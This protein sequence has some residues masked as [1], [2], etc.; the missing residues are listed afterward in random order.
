MHLKVLH[1]QAKKCTYAGISLLRLIE[2]DRE[3][4]AGERTVVC[5]RETR[6]F[7]PWSGVSQS[8]TSSRSCV[9][10]LL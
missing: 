6:T 4:R 1:K 5:V 7:E 9:P 3:K 2:K 10:D 8:D